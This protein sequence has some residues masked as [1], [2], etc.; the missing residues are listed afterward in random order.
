MVEQF[1]C[2][3]SFSAL[4]GGQARRTYDLGLSLTVKSEGNQKRR[5]GALRFVT[6][7]SYTIALPQF[8]R[9]CN[10]NDNDRINLQGKSEL[11]HRKSLGLHLAQRKRSNTAKNF[12]GCTS[13]ALKS[14]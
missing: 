14:V 6:V 10:G 3:N 13:K 11:L 8:P 2:F 4:E 12:K 9:L 5:T 7:G 1:C